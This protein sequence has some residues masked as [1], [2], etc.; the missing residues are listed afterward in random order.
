MPEA[1]TLKV[2]DVPAAT[3]CPM[4]WAEIEG[5]R[6]MMTVATLLVIDPNALSMTTV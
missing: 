4:G 3:V 1:V 2:R 5:G 6:P